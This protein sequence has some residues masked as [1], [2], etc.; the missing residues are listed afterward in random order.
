[1]ANPKL[2]RAPR[3]TQ[4]A[5]ESLRVT[6]HSSL[7]LLTNEETK[8][9]RAPPFLPPRLWER[10]GI[11]TSLMS[12]QEEFMPSYILEILIFLKITPCGFRNVSRALGRLSLNCLLLAV[13][14]SLHLSFLLCKTRW[15]HK[16][17]DI[18]VPQR[19]GGHHTILS[20]LTLYHCRGEE[21]SSFGGRWVFPVMLRH[22]GWG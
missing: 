7:Q 5:F 22:W 15:C 9:A 12:P 19:K 18:P 3:V 17:P 4:Q 16:T 6:P 20:W 1:M 21:V 8:A 13:L 10:G 14:T 11:H 2:T